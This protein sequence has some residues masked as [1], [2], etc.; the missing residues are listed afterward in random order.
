MAKARPGDVSIGKF[1]ILATYTYSR[2]LLDGLDD[3]E[4]KERGMVAAIMGAQAR[5]RHTVGAHHDE[6]KAEKQS[7]EK[8]KK[9]TITAESFDRRV[10][11]KM[12]DFFGDV[13]LPSVKR[14]VEAGLSYGEVKRLV[15]IPT[16]WG[17][18]I[19][20]EQ[21]R[22]RAAAAPREGKKR[23]ISRPEP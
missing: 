8:K 13:F 10:A 12:G 18:K 3:D 7:A 2:G 22:E 23:R 15:K 16:T 9:T 4:A 21:F 11:D 5:S 19:T 17:A 20:G 1:D 14:L 6:Y